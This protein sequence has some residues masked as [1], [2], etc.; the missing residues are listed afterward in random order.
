MA[1]TLLA[2]ASAAGLEIIVGAVA[3]RLVQRGGRIEQ[4]EYVDS[5]SRQTHAL[6]ADLVVLAAGA[7]NSRP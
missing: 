4:V 3:Q 2:A 5:A 7:L 6:S 1:S